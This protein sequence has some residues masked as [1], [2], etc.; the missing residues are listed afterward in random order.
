MAATVLTPN[1]GLYADGPDARECL[2][3]FVDRACGPDVGVAWFANGTLTPLRAP[4]R[5]N[6][7]FGDAAVFE[8]GPGPASPPPRPR[9]FWAKFEAFFSDALQRYGDAELASS[10]AN[11]AASQALGNALG[12]LFTSH[13]DDGA[14]VV[15]DIVCVGLSVALIFTGI[16]A[17]GAIAFAGSVVL[18]GA[19]GIAYAKEMGGDEEGAEAFKK[20]TEIIRLVATV[21]TLPDLAWGGL[22]AIREFRE[23]EELSQMS[24]TTANTAEAL[25]ARTSSASRARRYADIAERAHLRTQLRSEQIRAAIVHE[26][27]PRAAGAVGL[28]LLGREEWKSEQSLL[29]EFL[30]RLRAHT[31][32]VHG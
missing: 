22:K 32:A 28:V 1:W 26:F 31:V 17:L 20:Q 5:D 14:G 4:R 6:G 27:S 2:C 8:L 24:R 23:V 11:L 15:L 21:A 25:A 13:A 16:G 29:N 19:D 12:K 30:Q 3:R 7:G 9:G 10:Q 18:A